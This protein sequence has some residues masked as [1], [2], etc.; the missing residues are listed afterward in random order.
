MTAPQTTNSVLLITGASGYVGRR[1]SCLARQ[2]G[3]EVVAAVRER[4]TP[5]AGSRRRQFDLTA[6]DD[7]TELLRGVDC[8]VH[9][10]AILDG[11]N[12]RPGLDEELNVH[13]SR[14]LI[15]AARCA[16]V[17]RFVFLSSQSAAEDSPTDYGRSKFAIE[18]LLDRA[19]ECA[20]RTGL[21]SGGAPRG[22]FGSL[23]T[24]SR[25]L[26]L[27]PML[28]GSAP[29]YPLHIDDLCEGL[30]SIVEQ[31]AAPPRLLRICADKPMRFDDYVRLVGESRAGRRV[32]LLPLP[33]M[34]V[35]I[36]A[37]IAS[38]LALLPAGARDRILGLMALRPMDCDAIPTPAGAPPLIDLPHALKA[39]GLRRRLLIEGRLLTRYLGC[40]ASGV[41]RRYA[42]AVELE[43]DREP[44]RLP[45]GWLQSRWSFALAEP[46]SNTGRW[47]R[48]LSIATRIVETVPASAA[49][50]HRYRPGSR[51]GTVLQLG[52]IVGLE[53]L[54]MP[55]R[56]LFGRRRE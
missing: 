7:L 9:L 12:R 13:G 48:R 33:S 27:I 8:V 20:V 31:P 17:R 22:L 23:C 18:A 43:P 40:D 5:P 37:R 26:P 53:A 14:R 56:L 46:I 25:K 34:L 28:R 29:I 47:G 42:R 19:G 10:A 44:L 30:L 11:R 50:F 36:G 51:V 21:V 39:E 41:L 1:L 4:A 3:H 52:W 55:F 38:A 32:R 49:T 35:S 2:R 45:A 54:R 6:E 15:E 16:G 24:M